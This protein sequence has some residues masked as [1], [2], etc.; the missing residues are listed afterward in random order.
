MEALMGSVRASAK[1][2]LEAIL[3]EALPIVT[4]ITAVTDE[5]LAA[6]T[7]DI[8]NIRLKAYDHKLAS[9]FWRD[10][11][12][13]LTADD[14]S[15]FFCEDTAFMS[16]FIRAICEKTNEALTAESLLAD[17]KSLV[18]S[19][20][21]FLLPQPDEMRSQSEG[22]INDDTNESVCHRAFRLRGSMWGMNRDWFVNASGRLPHMRAEL[23]RQLP[24]TQEDC[25]KIRV[26]SL[27]QV[28]LQNL[29]SAKENLEGLAADERQRNEDFLEAQRD[30]KAAS[31]AHDVLHRLL[32][33][34][35]DEKRG[36]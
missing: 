17:A 4:E 10:T 32:I 11:Q 7:R 23:E 8:A 18:S 20:L 25:V 5:G 35:E 28:I 2:R 27:C 31:S 24:E 9:V 26:D 34:V 19:E 13:Y 14:S 15:W 29:K 36:R 16:D 1:D 12:R 30:S 3:A 6:N 33:A 21:H 22:D